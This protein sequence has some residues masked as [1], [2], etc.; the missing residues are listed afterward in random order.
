VVFHE[1]SGLDA[2]AVRRVQAQVRQRVLRACVRRGL[3]DPSA[4][5][6]MGGWAHG[7]GFFDARRQKVVLTGVKRSRILGVTHLYFLSLAC[8]RAAC[9]VDRR[10][11]PDLGEGGK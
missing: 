2:A 5:E 1:A 7:G 11:N 3:L 9:C 8:C 10:S 4:G 6:E